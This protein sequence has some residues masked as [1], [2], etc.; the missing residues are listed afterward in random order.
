MVYK[1]DFFTFPEFV[2]S[3]SLIGSLA[4]LFSV[5]NYYYSSSFNP[6]WMLTVLNSAS[7]ATISFFIL[8]V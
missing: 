7:T 4:K 3:R 2:P 6:K 1:L 5:L 8:R